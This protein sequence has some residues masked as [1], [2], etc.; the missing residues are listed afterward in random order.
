MTAY[1]SHHE[2]LPAAPKYMY[3]AKQD[4][5]KRKFP[6]PR[7]DVSFSVYA[8]QPDQGRDRDLPRRKRVIFNRGSGRDLHSFSVPARPGSQQQTP[9]AGPASWSPGRAPP[10]L[11]PVCSVVAHGPGSDRTAAPSPTAPLLRPSAGGRGASRSARVPTC[12]ASRR[13]RPP[14]PPSSGP[15]ASPRSPWSPGEGTAG[16]PASGGSGTEASVRPQRAARTNPR[17]R[18]LPFP[19][20]GAAGRG[21]APPGGRPDALSAAPVPEAARNGEAH[22][23][24]HTDGP[25]AGRPL[26][27]PA[28]RTAGAAAGPGSHRRG[29]GCGPRGPRS[30]GAASPPARGSLEQRRSEDGVS[31]GPAPRPGPLLPPPPP[32]PPRAP[33]GFAPRT[34]RRARGWRTT[35]ARLPGASSAGCGQV[36]GLRAGAPGG[37]SGRGRGHPRPRSHPRVRLPAPRETRPQSSRNAGASS[38]Q[39]RP[40]SEPAELRAARGS[41]RVTRGAALR[42]GRGPGR[43]GCGDGA[44]AGSCALPASFPVTAPTRGAPS[45]HCSQGRRDSALPLLARDGAEPGSRARGCSRSAA[46]TLRTGFGFAPQNTAPRRK[47][48]SRSSDRGC[49]PRRARAGGVLPHWPAGRPAPSGGSRDRGSRA[50]HGALLGGVCSRGHPGGLSDPAA[51]R[52]RERAEPPHDPDTSRPP[53]LGTRTSIPAP[54]DPGALDGKDRTR[55]TQHLPDFRRAAPYLLLN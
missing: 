17:P 30:S 37:G 43:A 35:G 27:S 28:R 13:R 8:W 9:R 39:P 38:P 41:A 40:A 1:V 29:A 52:R 18:G 3:Y 45:P 2:L 51:A 34:S 32:R 42:P 55:C 4:P 47:P 21:C 54:P 15:G 24:A 36:G 22:G 20:L 23:R 11:V 26:P 5:V 19:G 12:P 48:V 53:A 44:G 49:P 25:R 33:R 46:E 6:N 50:L 16:A 7:A 31:F 14:A 10:R